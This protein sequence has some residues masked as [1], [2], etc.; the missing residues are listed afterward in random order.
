MTLLTRANSNMFE[1]QGLQGLN[2]YVSTMPDFSAAGSVLCQANV[3]FAAPG[4][5][6]KP[7][8]S[9]RRCRGVTPPLPVAGCSKWTTAC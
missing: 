9:T 2:G 3:S 4:D 7:S 6:Q 1:S 8:A 5:D